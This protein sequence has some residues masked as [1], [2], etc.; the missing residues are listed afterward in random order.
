MG[1]NV[2]AMHTMLINKPPDTGNLTSRHPLHQDLHYF[3]F[4]PAD[5]IVCAWTALERVHRGNGCLVVQ[6]GSHRAP[7][8]LLKHGY[9]QWEGGVNKFYHG[10]TELGADAP[11]THL[12]MEAGDTVLFHPLL[13]HG[14]GANRT[15]GYR[16]VRQFGSFSICVFVTNW[17]RTPYLLT[18]RHCFL[19][20]S[21]IFAVGGLSWSQ[22]LGHASAGGKASVGVLDLIGCHTMINDK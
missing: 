4:R 1:P 15:A 8:R 5:R 16:K 12:E 11:R 17:L 2:M 18:D 22:F 6:P 21:A 19:Y 7:G 9:P 3:P 10:I 13:I 20:H 14:S